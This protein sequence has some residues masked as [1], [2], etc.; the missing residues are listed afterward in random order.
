MEIDLKEE[1]KKQVYRE[2]MDIDI[3]KLT[4]LWGET[5]Y[6]QLNEGQYTKL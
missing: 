6:I 1:L 2:K 4:D 3:E 5:K